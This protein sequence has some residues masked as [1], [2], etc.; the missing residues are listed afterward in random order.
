MKKILYTIKKYYYYFTR[1]AN[2]PADVYIRKDWKVFYPRE[3]RMLISKEIDWD[4]IELKY[5]Q[6]F[7]NRAYSFGQETKRSSPAGMIWAYIA[8]YCIVLYLILFKLILPLFSL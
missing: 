4:D 2:V 6:E 3:Q 1:V 7:Y 8:G 5:K